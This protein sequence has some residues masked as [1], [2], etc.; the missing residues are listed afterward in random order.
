MLDYIEIS[1]NKQ[2]LTNK[3]LMA[4]F[5]NFY[6][7]KLLFELVLVYNHSIHNLKAFISSLS[8]FAR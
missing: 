3:F 5:S 1:Q 6:A 2:K 4:I 7:L 8:D